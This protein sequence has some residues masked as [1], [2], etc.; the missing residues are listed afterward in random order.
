M[1]GSRFW[2]LGCILFACLSAYLAFDNASLRFGQYAGGVRDR[3]VTA[4]R[5]AMFKLIPELRP[6]L[7]ADQVEAAAK[8]AKLSLDR[9]AETLRVIGG[10]EFV[11]T[12]TEISGVRSSN[13]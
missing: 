7:Q 5:D 3:F 13:F 4:Q 8:A 6:P 11:L 1:G 12:G 2:V 10:I 9:T